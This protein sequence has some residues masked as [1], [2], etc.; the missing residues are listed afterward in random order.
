ML[1]VMKVDTLT[2]V[3]VSVDRSEDVTVDVGAEGLLS[4]VVK[5]VCGTAV[6][7]EELATGISS[8]EGF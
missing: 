8:D 4:V 1:T 2:Q 3:V 6:A 5:V 7:E